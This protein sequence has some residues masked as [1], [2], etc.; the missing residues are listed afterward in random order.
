MPWGF[1][2]IMIKERGGK[3]ICLPPSEHQHTW[4]SFTSKSLSETSKSQDAARSIGTS[5]H[6]AQ[7][8]TWQI[9]RPK[10]SCAHLNPEPRK[11]PQ[12]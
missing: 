10:T 8:N 2:H 1:L 5:Y 12:S 6:I 4:S 7:L 11:I 9:Q 3:E